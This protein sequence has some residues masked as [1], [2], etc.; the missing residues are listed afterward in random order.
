MKWN[1]KY[2]YPKSTRSMINGSRHYSLDGSNLPSV[3]T[4]LKATQSEEDKAGIAAWKERVGHKEAERIST[5]AKSRG[6]AMH[7]Y[8]EKYLLGQLIQELVEEN[9]K[10]KQMAEII[11]ENGIKNKMSEIWGVESTL[12]YPNK[13]AGTADCICVYEGKETIVD[14]KQS[15]KP[16]KKEY[17]ED[18]FLQL[19]AYSLAHNII[20]NS[21][22]TQCV[23]LLCTVDNLFQDFKIEGEQLIQFQNKFLEK[24]EQFYHQLETN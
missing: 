5:E 12:Y 20:Y 7:S 8:L 4:I 24:V 3:T 10:S 23:V 13:Y 18:Y 17:I 1:N 2:N 9:N 19:G 11:I 15:N 16:K 21:K 6:S 22:I 14:F